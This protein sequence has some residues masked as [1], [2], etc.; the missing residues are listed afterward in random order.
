MLT[1]TS[2]REESGHWELQFYNVTIHGQLGE[3]F[4]ASCKTGQRVMI[5]GRVDCELRETLM[6]YQPVVSIIATSIITL[7]GTVEHNSVAE[8]LNLV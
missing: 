2:E 6:G 4:A 7:Y 1:H 8:Q 3:S 5:T